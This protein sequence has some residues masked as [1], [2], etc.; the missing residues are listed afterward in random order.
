MAAPHEQPKAAATQSRGKST[1]AAVDFLFGRLNY[2][3]TPTVPYQEQHFKLERMFELAERL[4]NPQNQFPIIHVAGS[5]G[6]GSTATM[7]SAILQAAGQQVGLYTSPHIES[8][9]ERIR[10]NSLPCSSTE[11][12]ALLE[13]I[14]PHV[15]EMD[16][17]IADDQSQRGPTYF[18]ILTAAGLLHF[19]HQKVDAA[20]LEVG[21][22]GRLDST[23]ICQ[24]QC[25]V[26][27]SISKDHTRQLGDTL[28]KIAAEKA[29]IVKKGVPVVCGVTA[30][31]AQAVIH[32][33]AKACDAPIHQRG[34]DFDF[35]LDEQGESSSLFTY[36]EFQLANGG[37][38]ESGVETLAL[39]GLRTGMLG[40]HQKANA[41]VAVRT[42]RLFTADKTAL[43]E[44]AIRS[45]LLS[46]QCPARIEVV[47]E[48]PLLIVDAAHNEASTEALAKTLRECWPHHQKTFVVAATRGK[49]VE[50]I[51]RHLLPIARQ[52]I[53]TRYLKNPRCYDPY[54]L[55]K[56]AGQ[57]RT[58]T[59]TNAE[60]E[61]ELDPQTALERARAEQGSEE[62]VCVTGSFFLAAELR[63]L[64][65]QNRSPS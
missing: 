61:V 50:G 8:P 65:T 12:D 35:A 11:F 24:P 5:K 17:A 63:A 9:E 6:K 62:L 56:V 20:V 13:E 47:S 19:A 29:G 33:K 32:A 4:G 7:I 59:D 37:A 27:T 18:E 34:H 40:T 22:G 42:A 28:A 30:R 3:R 60:I 14:Q 46:A 55:S 51:F 48:S 38:A 26:I 25:C 52:M 64:I 16:L 10:L 43:D 44:E 15:I 58:T 36:R 31:E 53:L 1:R 2:E 54:R 57:V 21:L 45:G 49:D 39:S 41:A 23:N